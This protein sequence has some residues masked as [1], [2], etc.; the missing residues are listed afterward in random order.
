MNSKEEL[1]ELYVKQRNS[2]Q[3]IADIYNVPTSRI[4]KAMKEFEIPIR[5]HSE[6][7][8]R[9]AKIK[10]D[11]LYDLYVNQK[12]SMKEISGIFGVSKTLIQYYMKNYGIESRKRGNPQWGKY[13]RPVAKNKRD[14]NSAVLMIMSILKIN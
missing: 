8:R 4:K 10:K 11:A 5:S 3:T 14:T 7:N 2:I 13:L 9:P 12:K 6:A 1:Y